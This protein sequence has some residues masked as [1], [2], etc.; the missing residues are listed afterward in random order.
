MTVC[1]SVCVAVRCWYTETRRKTRIG[2][3]PQLSKSP[4]KEK[5]IEMQKC[6]RNINKKHTSSLAVRDLS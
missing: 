2:D 3:S 4:R 1:V 6:V 5:K